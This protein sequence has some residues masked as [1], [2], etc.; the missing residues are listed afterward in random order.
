MDLLDQLAEPAADLLARVDRTL[1]LGGVPAGHSIEPLLRRLRALPGAAAGAIIALQ[2]ASLAAAGQT[3]RELTRA[4]DG[5]RAGLDAIDAWQG[6]AA[7]TFDIQR[8][9]LADHLAGGAESLLGRLT[10]TADHA[11][12]V[13]EWATRSR[14]ELAGTLVAALGSAEAVTLVTGT[15]RASPGV[16]DPSGV[17]AAAAVG[18]RVL[19]TVAD[20]YDQ[21]EM[22]L[23]RWP[24][25]LS[26][27]TYRP[28][29]DG[30]GGFDQTIRIRH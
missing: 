8:A 28:P 20:A 10:A 22:L 19:S 13:V 7:D 12:A 5:T 21:A 9:A 27:V 14:I 26:E 29:L 25:R 15:G 6:S 3:L 24:P 18:S 2:P 11:D 4:Y 23:H 17:R 1:T 16:G 30:V